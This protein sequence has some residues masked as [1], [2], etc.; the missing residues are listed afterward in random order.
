[1]AMRPFLRGPL[2]F[3]GFLLLFVA[4]CLAPGL[5]PG[6]PERLEAPAGLVLAII[7]VA[8]LLSRSQRAAYK[9]NW[10]SVSSADALS[11]LVAVLLAGATV[12]NAVAGGPGHRA[13]LAVLASALPAAL[14]LATVPRLE[15]MFSNLTLPDLSEQ[16]APVKGY[17]LWA[18]QVLVV[19]VLPVAKTSN[20]VALLIA[21]LG[22]VLAFP[23]APSLSG[24]AV[25][26]ALILFLVGYELFRQ[27]GSASSDAQPTSSRP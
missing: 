1:M 24:S 16:R 14:F 20:A 19:A 21:V 15:S 2:T 4:L 9:A 18:G 8:A 26:L 10:R 11:C 12:Y 27:S 23:K 22:F 7:V 3:V 6:V 17:Q 13:A 5:L 25:T